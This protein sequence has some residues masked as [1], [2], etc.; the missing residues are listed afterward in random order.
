MK[1]DTAV[2]AVFDTEKRTPVRSSIATFLK[3]HSNRIPAGWRCSKMDA[4]AFLAFVSGLGL[5]EDRD[6]AVV[7]SSLDPHA[8]Q[9]KW[10]GDTAARLSRALSDQPPGWL[11]AVYAC[12]HSLEPLP[13]GALTDIAAEGEPEESVPSETEAPPLAHAI[14]DRTLRIVTSVRDAEFPDSDEWISVFPRSYA[15]P[16]QCNESSRIAAWCTWYADTAPVRPRDVPPL[17]PM[18]V[19]EAYVRV[20]LKENNL[21]GWPKAPVFSSLELETGPLNSQKVRE[22]YRQVRVDEL[23][24]QGNLFTIPLEGQFCEG[25]SSPLSTYFTRN[26]ECWQKQGPQGKAGAWVQFDTLVRPT[27]DAARF[28][29]QPKDA[30]KYVRDLYRIAYGQDVVMSDFTRI[31]VHNL[32]PGVP[33]SED[34]TCDCDDDNYNGNLAGRVEDDTL[35]PYGLYYMGGLVIAAPGVSVWGA[36]PHDL[37]TSSAWQRQRTD[38]PIVNA[39]DPLDRFALR[40]DELGKEWFDIVHGGL[41]QDDT[42]SLQAFRDAFS[43]MERNPCDIGRLCGVDPGSRFFKTLADGWTEHSAFVGSIC[44]ILRAYSSPCLHTVEGSSTIVQRIWSGMTTDRSRNSED[45]DAFPWVP[46]TPV[47]GQLLA[48][49]RSSSRFA[50]NADRVTDALNRLHAHPECQFRFT[51]RESGSKER[52]NCVVMVETNVVAS[53]FLDGVPIGSVGELSERLRI[54][55]VA[56]YVYQACEPGVIAT[57][58]SGLRTVMDALNGRSRTGR[59]YRMAAAL[60]ASGYQDMFRDHVELSRNGAIRYPGIDEFPVDVRVTW[61]RNDRLVIL[62]SM[63]GEAA[64]FLRLMYRCDHK[65][66]LATASYLKS[67]GKAPEFAF[68]AD[69]SLPQSS[70]YINYLKAQMKYNGFIARGVTPTAFTGGQF[71]PV[72]NPE[73]VCG[74]EPDQYPDRTWYDENFAI[75][76]PMMLGVQ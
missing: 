7:R 30:A 70:N 72:Y 54:A 53:K 4:E 23:V 25:S 2:R 58:S 34:I 44:G 26:L 12:A 59:I 5:R 45:Q 24:P 19:V 9:L 48:E 40:T 29:L 17:A 22:L 71:S 68:M 67:R 62:F 39:G 1:I 16:T 6:Y 42:A 28:M 3:Q 52:R 13:E 55:F 37:D 50:E 75:N 66:P 43:G 18:P 33:G 8:I 57:A 35:L 51:E 36:S 76:I 20:C 65:L 46:S 61:D 10:L 73:S 14:A 32:F 31:A 11:D 47:V 63:D 60:T 38:L 27:V 69:S 15:E 49:T 74:L 64:Q 21:P 56:P 41:S